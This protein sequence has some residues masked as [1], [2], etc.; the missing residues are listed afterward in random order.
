MAKYPERTFRPS[1]SVPQDTAQLLR[2]LEPNQTPVFG[3]NTDNFSLAFHRFV[4]NEAIE[5]DDL[6]DDRGRA[7]DKVR[8]RWLRH[9]VSGFNTKDSSDLAKLLA[10]CAA[11][12]VSRT[13]TAT[14]FVSPLLSRLIVGLGGKGPI[15]IGITVHPITGLPYISGSA[16]K[17]LARNYAL[18]TLYADVNGE[19]DTLD[20]DALKAFDE[21]LC[22]GEGH[23]LA[24]TYR[25][26]FGVSAEVADD[27]GQAGGCIFYDAILLTCN[28]PIFSLDV[29]TPHF[30]EYYNSGNSNGRPTTAPHDADSPNP[31]TYITV[32]EGAEFA[33]AVGRRKGIRSA[34]EKQAARWLADALSEFGIGAKTAAGYG[35]FKKPS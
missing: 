15:E 17:G 3:V 23:E 26:A 9:V 4:P 28:G 22:R 32:T 20:T 2:Q 25:D 19:Q 21:M 7:I 31:V 1:Y 10:A 8:A 35:V 24:P 12:W 5:T 16:L 29:M 6:L 11:L 18:L 14:R 13:E 27:S 33:F 34:V 30:K